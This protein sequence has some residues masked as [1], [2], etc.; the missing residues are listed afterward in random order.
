MLEKEV[1][2]YKEAL[3]KHDIYIFT[4][5]YYHALEK[6]PETAEK[7]KQLQRAL[8]VAEEIAN[9]CFNQYINTQGVLLDIGPQ[10]TED[11]ITQINSWL[12][13]AEKE[14]RDL[15]EK[16]EKLKEDPCAAYVPEFKT[17]RETVLAKP[18]QS[19]SVLEYNQ[20]HSIAYYHQ[21]EEIYS[22]MIDLYRACYKS[23]IK[24]M[25]DMIL[26]NSPNLAATQTV[27]P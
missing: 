13:L 7:L 3:K 9:M 23:L 18:L 19:L 2:A 16:I 14:T 1:N 12:N 17:I 20:E 10:T 22:N 8:F 6:S 21:L 5:F 11:Q 25:D 26:E 24:E 15:L 27:A 4:S